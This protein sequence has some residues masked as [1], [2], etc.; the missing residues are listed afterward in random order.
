MLKAKLTWYLGCMKN[1]N[2]LS[3]TVKMMLVYMFTTISSVYFLD[4]LFL[5]SLL[6]WADKNQRDTNRK[7][8]KKSETD[9]GKT[10]L[11]LGQY[12]AN[13]KDK[14]SVGASMVYC[15]LE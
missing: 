1:K 2:E 4:R 3:S 12:V 11:P 9:F 14:T 15:S 8:K 6:T 10:K 7:M 5:Y 13:I